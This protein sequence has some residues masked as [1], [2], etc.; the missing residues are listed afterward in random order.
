MS[1]EIVPRPWVPG[2][3]AR[4]WLP[5]WF[6]S[7]F[8]R[9][10]FGNERNVVWVMSK[11]FPIDPSCDFIL[12]VFPRKDRITHSV[13]HIVATCGFSRLT[14]VFVSVILACC[15]FLAKQSRRQ[16][17]VIIRVTVPGIYVTFPRLL[18]VCPEIATGQRPARTVNWENYCVYLFKTETQAVAIRLNVTSQASLQSFKTNMCVL[19][20]FFLYFSVLW[21]DTFLRDRV[22]GGA[23]YREPCLV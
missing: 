20:V 9:F 18:R 14:T 21:S 11:R 22:S 23:P 17:F 19:S 6:C 8:S 3:I 12:K 5:N 13:S 7:L 15:F 2:C 10:R 16:E 4:F 1:M